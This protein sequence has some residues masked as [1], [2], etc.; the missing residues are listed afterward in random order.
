MDKATFL[1]RANKRAGALEATITPG[2]CPPACQKAVLEANADMAEY[3]GNGL[4]A[5]IASQ[6]VAAMPKDKHFSLGSL[7]LSPRT[8]HTIV[9]LVGVLLMWVANALLSGCPRTPDAT[10][11]SLHTAV[12]EIRELRAQVASIEAM[13]K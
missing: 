12:R 9:T 1:A 2:A 5:E 10:A 7:N 4:G 6:V 13:E 3:L 8:I 11:A